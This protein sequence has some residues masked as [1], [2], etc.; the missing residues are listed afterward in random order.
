[1]DFF[2]KNLVIK[3]ANIIGPNFNLLRLQIGD[4]LGVASDAV[5]R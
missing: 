1:M 2:F 3:D 4:L 5:L